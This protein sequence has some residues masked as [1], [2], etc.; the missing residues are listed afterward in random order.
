MTGSP[1]NNDEPLFR[2]GNPNPGKFGFFSL[3]SSAGDEPDQERIEEAALNLKRERIVND[4]A[5]YECELI[6]A[7]TR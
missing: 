5:G 4:E 6:A 3:R 7:A 2:K 1:M